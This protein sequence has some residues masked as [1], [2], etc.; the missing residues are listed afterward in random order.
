MLA[1]TT[2]ATTDTMS[3][4]RHATSVAQMS[5]EQMNEYMQQQQ[6]IFA[7]ADEGHSAMSS[8]PV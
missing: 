5:A 6:A 7:Q 2:A 4:S 1:T 8:A 3:S